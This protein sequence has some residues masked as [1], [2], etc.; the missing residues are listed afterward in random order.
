M[1]YSAT[2]LLLAGA[3][4]LIACLL[5]FLKK[6]YIPAGILFASAF[7]VAVLFSK[8]TA[9]TSDVASWLFPSR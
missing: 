7:I 6:K 9:G 3:V 4:L 5:C 8:V 2:F 1:S